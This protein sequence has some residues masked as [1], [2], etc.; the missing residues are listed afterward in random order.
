MLI[1][2]SRLSVCLSVCLSQHTACLHSGSMWILIKIISKIKYLILFSFR[3]SYQSADHLTVT[4]FYMHWHEFN[5]SEL[6]HDRPTLM[7]AIIG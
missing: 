3:I 1:C 6:F 5:E 2:Q 4:A 7:W